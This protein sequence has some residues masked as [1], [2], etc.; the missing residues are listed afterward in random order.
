MNTLDYMLSDKGLMIAKSKELKIRPL[1]K[2]KVADEKLK[3]QL[4]NL[5][6]PIVLMLIYGVSRAYFRKNKYTKF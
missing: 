2:V 4:I 1:D 3:W 6:I 5:L